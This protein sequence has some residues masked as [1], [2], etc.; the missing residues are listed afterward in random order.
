M[1][2]LPAQEHQDQICTSQQVPVLH[3]K[4]E[5]GLKRLM[6][7]PEV[8][9]TGKVLQDFFEKIFCFASWG[10]EN[11]IMIFGGDFGVPN[12]RNPDIHEMVNIL[13]YGMPL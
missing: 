10:T 1:D 8:S 12:Q 5:N 11:G 13:W 9:P 7:F 6:L 2:F 4:M 3:L